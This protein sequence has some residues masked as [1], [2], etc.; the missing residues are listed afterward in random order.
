LLVTV[1]SRSTILR[2]GHYFLTS[3]LWRPTFATACRDIFLTAIPLT[4]NTDAAASGSPGN[5]GK[6]PL[7]KNQP[8]SC[9]APTNHP[10]EKLMP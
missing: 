2:H 7:S 1:D 4:F 5:C 9:R 6:I 3:P 8:V 10:S